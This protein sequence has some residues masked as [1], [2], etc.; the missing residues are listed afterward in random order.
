[1]LSMFAHPGRGVLQAGFYCKGILASSMRVHVCKR[2]R[3]QMPAVHPASSSSAAAGHMHAGAMLY[4]D[5][6]CAA[7]MHSPASPVR[8]GS[9]EFRAGPFP[10]G[11]TVIVL[12]RTGKNFGAGMSGGL[13]FVHDPER[14]LGPLCN[15]DV[16]GDLSALEDEEVGRA[17]LRRESL[18]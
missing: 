15:E 2:D 1:M 17:L 16:A 13:A 9:A 12:G 10:A 6:H 14:R 7:C 5:A 4:G 11:G 18:C 8:Q 3:L